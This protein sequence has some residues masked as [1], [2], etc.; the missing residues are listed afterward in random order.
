[1]I[2]TGGQLHAGDV[3]APTIKQHQGFT[4]RVD[5]EVLNKAMRGAGTN[6]DAIIAV[7]TK[8][9]WQQR[10][11]IEN[12]YKQ[13]FGKELS[14]HIGDE[15]GVAGNF[16][17]VME[18]LL[19]TPSELAAVELR[20]AILGGNT[21]ETCLIEIICSRTDAETA[22]IKM[23][24]AKRFGVSLEK[25]ICGDTS[26]NFRKLLH[27]L[28]ATSRPEGQPINLAAVASDVTALFQAGQARAGTD[29]TRFN[30]IFTSRSSAHLKAVFEGYH[31][32]HGKDIEDVIK[33]EFSGFIEEALLAI[34]TCVRNKAAFFARCLRNSMVGAGTKDQALI[35]LIVSRA[36]FDLGAVKVE[37]LK[38]YGKTL[39]K[40]IQEESTGDYRKALISIIGE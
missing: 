17:R 18:M 39:A 8:R 33:V 31:R 11:E 7:L 35:R 26:G 2:I 30:V 16:F 36:D 20:R 23:E 13:M 19:R 38:L 12:V 10:A 28:L 5:C 6:E 27:L 40:A 15:V 14:R 34:A 29:E 3:F 4:P 37:Y 9:S 32:T 21:D 24:Y 22:A 1:V 25:D